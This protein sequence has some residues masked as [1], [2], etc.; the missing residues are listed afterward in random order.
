MKIQQSDELTEAFLRRC[1]LEL[2]NVIHQLSLLLFMFLVIRMLLWAINIP[3]R[4]DEE[5][6]LSQA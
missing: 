4:E 6:R 3:D 2:K 1:I 5:T